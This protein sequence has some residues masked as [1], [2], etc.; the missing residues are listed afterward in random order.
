MTAGVNKDILVGA[1]WK[2]N[3]D[4]AQSLEYAS[5]LNRFCLENITGEDNIEVFFLPTFLPLYHMRD[6][7]TA[8]SLKYGAQNCCWEDEGAFTGEVSPAHLKDAGCTYV[9]LGHAERRRIFGEDDRMLNK[10]VLAALRNGLKPILCIGE[11]E[12]KDNMNATYDFL[13][14]Q[15]FTGLN[16]VDSGR[17]DD[18]IIAYEPVWAIGASE[19][20]PLDYTEKILDFLRKLL[21]NRYG[22]EVSEKQMIFYGGAVNP[23]TAPGIL[24]LEQ[25]DGIFIGRA[26]LDIKYLIQLVEMALEHSRRGK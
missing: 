1:A 24:E 8:P 15:L 11:R 25:N 4:L 6:I 16:N 13:K 21:K 22:S 12:K 18:V 17:L 10:K 19:S 5:E 20:A 26:S 2:M 7:V 9:E 23:D 3:K 14:D